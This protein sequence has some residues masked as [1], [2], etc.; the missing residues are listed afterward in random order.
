MVGDLGSSLSDILFLQKPNQVSLV[1][2]FHCVKIEIMLLYHHMNFIAV[3]Y[4]EYLG[5]RVIYAPKI[6]IR[7]ALKKRIA[8]W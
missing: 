5:R 3:K 1:L 8:T 7:Y 6:M 2:E 4:F